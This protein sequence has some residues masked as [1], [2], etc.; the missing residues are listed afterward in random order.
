MEGEAAVRSENWPLIVA[1][2][3]NVTQSKQNQTQKTAVALT[4]EARFLFL[5]L[6]PGLCS[7][8]VPG[9]ILL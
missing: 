7:G 1:Q 8:P 4:A 5:P 3:K 2:A 6:L 9:P